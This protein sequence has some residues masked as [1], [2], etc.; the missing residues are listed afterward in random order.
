MAAKVRNKNEKK[1]QL[2]FVNRFDQ[3]LCDIYLS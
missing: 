1:K 3:V 2:T